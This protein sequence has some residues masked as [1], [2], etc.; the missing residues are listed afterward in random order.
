[1]ERESTPTLGGERNPVYDLY[2]RIHSVYGDTWCEEKLEASE[3]ACFRVPSL[4]KML[5]R[6]FLSSQDKKYIQ[7]VVEGMIY[8][9]AQHKL[10]KLPCEDLIN[11]RLAA[12]GAM[13][14][15]QGTVVFNININN[16]VAEAKPTINI[17]VDT[18][19]LED[20]ARLLEYLLQEASKNMTPR[21]RRILEQRVKRAERVLEDLIVK[22][23]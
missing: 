23:N 10:G 16:N 5:Y 21:T 1:M 11:K 18:K 7:I 2:T 15:G 6:D 4:A 14:T 9:A 13:T 19:A 22:L 12:I 17:N 8:A 3:P 20:I